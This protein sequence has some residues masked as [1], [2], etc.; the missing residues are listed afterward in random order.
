MS[1]PQQYKVSDLVSI[2]SINIIRV[3]GVMFILLRVRF[4]FGFILLQVRFL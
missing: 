2:G 1:V 3:G 4:L